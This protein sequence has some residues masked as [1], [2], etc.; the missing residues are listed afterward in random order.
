MLNKMVFTHKKTS[1]KPLKTIYDV[2]GIRLNCSHHFGV[3]C[4]GCFLQI[5]ARM[6]AGKIVAAHLLV[7]LKPSSSF[8]TV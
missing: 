2:L 8:F 1:N 3:F 5:I 7:R 4:S 6:L